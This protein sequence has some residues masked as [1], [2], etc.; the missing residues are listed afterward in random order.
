MSIKIPLERIPRSPE[1]RQKLIGKRVE[2]EEAHSREGL[3]I[4]QRAAV[5]SLLSKGYSLGELELNRSFSVALSDTTFP[6]KADIIVRLGGRAFLYVKCALNSPESWER[7]SLAFCRVV[8][9]CQIPYI[10]ITDGETARLITVSSC[11]VSTGGLEIIPSREEAETLLKEAAP[12]PFP[13]EKA[14]REKRILHAF[15]AITCP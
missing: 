6:V 12:V 9:D 15:D 8:E 10:L 4:V 14:E 5:D 2:Q 11:A 13:A 3:S 7:H 1:E